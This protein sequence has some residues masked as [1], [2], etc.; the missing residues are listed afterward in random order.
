M[1]RINFFSIIFLLFIVS[2]GI[3]KT[4]QS[5]VKY[6]F[7]ERAINEFVKTNLFKKGKVFVV[8]SLSLKKDIIYIGIIQD[9]MKIFAFESETE[10][11]PQ[12]IEVNNSLFI[13]YWKNGDFDIQESINLLKKYD[14]LYENTD[15]NYFS[16]EIV[17]DDNKKSFDVFFCKNNNAV[18]K[19][20]KSNIAVGY[21]DIPKL[22]CK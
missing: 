9:E 6:S 14:I 19:K 8:D 3:K 7:R 13:S 2:C 17:T 21:Y 22:K 18:F 16:F 5:D 12:C 15:E 20:V 4:T 1:K 10:K 11:I